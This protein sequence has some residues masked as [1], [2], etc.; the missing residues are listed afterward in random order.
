M[1]PVVPALLSL[2]VNHLSAFISS[3]LQVP[4]GVCINRRR[5]GK[6]PLAAGLLEMPGD[7]VGRLRSPTPH[8]HPRILPGG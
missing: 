7:Q 8:S 4:L 6:A 1:W 3:V 5:V 2:S